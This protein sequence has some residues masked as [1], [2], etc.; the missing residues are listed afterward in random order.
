MDKRSELCLLRRI[1]RIGLLIGGRLARKQARSAPLTALVC[2]PLSH[3][4]GSRSSAVG[5]RTPPAALFAAGV[6]LAGL[7]EGGPQGP[8]PTGLVGS[9]AIRGSPPVTGSWSATISCHN[10]RAQDLVMRE[11]RYTIQQGSHRETASRLA[12][13][14]WQHRRDTAEYVGASK[15]SG[16]EGRLKTL[17]HNCR[18]ADAEPR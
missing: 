5:A 11:E 1:G 18:I 12:L 13:R 17:L 10:W 6:Q 8:L 2:L 4:E 9:R 15:Q 7:Q 14:A 16:V 3:A